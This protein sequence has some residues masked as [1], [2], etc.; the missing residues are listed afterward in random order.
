MGRA[1]EKLSNKFNEISNKTQRKGE[2]PK[3][4]G[5]GFVLSEDLL[6]GLH[7]FLKS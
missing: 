7:S 5:V 4:E 2:K 3:N 6:V 1:K